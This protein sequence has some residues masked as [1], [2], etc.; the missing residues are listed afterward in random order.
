MSEDQA[1]TRDAPLKSAFADVDLWIF[2]LDN[3]L[4]PAECN[5]FR[6]IDARMAAFIEARLNLAHADA[7]KLQKDYYVRYGTT[8][9]GLMREH[10]VAPGDFLDFVH[11]ID[12]SVV[13]RN[14]TLR[15]NIDALPGRKFVFTNGTVAHAENVLARIGLTD[16][17]ADI[18]DIEAA[19]YTPKPHR[20]AYDRF[21]GRAGAAP[22]RAAMFEDIAHN[23][24][25][26]HARGMTTVL[27]ASDAPWMDDEPPEKRPAHRAEAIDADHVHHVTDDLTDFLRR[28][29]PGAEATDRPDK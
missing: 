15:A 24:A 20:E 21:L 10:G 16:L 13:P 27:V 11:D 4:Y 26:P 14:P 18:F 7:R 19:A 5:L 3:T 23:L 17:F 8:L 2:D 22:E 9:S 25:E 12:A 29:A 28:I 1:A 6:Q